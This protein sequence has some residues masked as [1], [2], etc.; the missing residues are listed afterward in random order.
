MQVLKNYLYNL[1]YQILVL[2]LPLIT[3]PYISKVLGAAGVGDFSFTYANVQYFVILGMIGITLYG[4]RQIA[5]VR[6]NSEKLKN[7]FYSI[8]TL[9]AITVSISFI[10]YLIFVFVFNNNEYKW[11]YMMQGINIIAALFDISWF[12]MG[13]EKFKETVTR[14]TLVKL[15]SLACIFIFVKT[16]ED[17]I[18]YTAILGLSSLIGN[19]T[20]WIYIPKVIGFKNIKVYKLKL[21]LKSVLALFVPQ[22]AVHIYLLLDRTMLG[23]IT[24]T[25]QVGYYENSQKMINMALNITGALTIVM[26][27]KIA[28]TFAKGDIKKVK[29]YIK[30]S[31]FFVNA[32]GIPLMFGL[33]GISKELSPW[34]FTA[35][36]V[37][38]D[39][40]IIVSSITI[41]L[42][43]WSKVIGS[44]FL[45]PLNK[46]K[47]YTIS[48]SLGALVN[49]SLNL[50]ILKKFGAMGACISTII[51]EFTVTSVQL[52]FM[53]E[54][55]KLKELINPVLLFIPAGAIMYIVVRIIGNIM[56]GGIL[57]NLVQ[58][59]SGALVYFIII[60]LFYRI[61]KKQSI[62]TYIKSI[63]RN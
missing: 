38:I 58:A 39:K 11:L 55:I 24:N 9:Q 20:F 54:F 62:T 13:I 25:V 4:N 51:S 3:V 60:E 1:S 41:L 15:V 16:P 19:L 61:F 59:T 26:M 17:T 40:L 53:K 12:F 28:N 44:Q 43:S 37:G 49:F 63:I 22:I 32:L 30:N 8:Y 5:Y 45:I 46:N 10:L 36:F 18:K 21:H 2:I 57:T 23:I 14:N 47:E 7:T 29:Y 27:P 35:K 31:F 33:M 6:E 34:F 56:G 48:V 52:Y 42:M 50:F